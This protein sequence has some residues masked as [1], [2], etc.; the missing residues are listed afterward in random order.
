MKTYHFLAGV[1][2]LALGIV[3]TW[4][5]QA[6]LRK[7]AGPRQV[8]IQ[9]NLLDCEERIAF[10]D[11]R[12]RE[13][14]DV[15]RPYLVELAA[16]RSLNEASVFRLRSICRTWMSAN[17]AACCEFLQRAGY[18]RLLIA[19]FL[20]DL[21]HLDPT[22]GMGEVIQSAKMFDD[23]TVREMFLCS[24]I[25]DMIESDANAAFEAIQDLPLYLRR[26]MQQRVAKKWIT[27]D[28]SS[29]LRTF[30][31]SESVS[32]DTLSW[33][34]QEAAKADL[35]QAFEVLNL[36]SSEFPKARVVASM[37]A[38]FAVAQKA[39]PA[40]GMEMLH[41]LP[42]SPM[43]SKHLTAML[44]ELG[45]TDGTVDKFR[46]IDKLNTFEA[47]QISTKILMGK[48]IAL[49]GNFAAV[50]PGVVARS[51]L[52]REIGAAGVGRNPRETFQWLE[53][54]NDP[55][56]RAEALDSAFS[57]WLQKDPVEVFR[58]ITSNEVKQD[59]AVR[60][61]ANLQLLD[62]A[63]SEDAQLRKQ[64]GVQLRSLSTP[65]KIAVKSVIYNQFDSV[66]ASKLSALFE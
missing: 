12:S 63:Y 49:A 36:H 53:S 18:L 44:G 65:A 58:F 9:S 20:P 46:N 40:L 3:Y 43:R 15:L 45:V 2:V 23:A 57:T 48:N 25:E 24:A 8:A 21:R 1:L 17:P 47:L 7:A 62:L 16:G 55:V 64:V 19:D 27:L 41:R 66:T 14:L 28:L 39:N 30:M 33:V 54:L 11:P 13:F 5:N 35:Q 52:F 60:R 37:N 59:S 6:I 29:A 34:L 32:S 51:N 56:V 31:R 22:A 61:G 10:A 26:R 42:P 4:L 50:V 38:I